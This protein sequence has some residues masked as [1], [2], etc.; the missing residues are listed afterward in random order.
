SGSGG[1]N[2]RRPSPRQAGRASRIGS[3]SKNYRRASPQRFE[4]GSLRS[5]RSSDFR[6]DRRRRRK[7][8]HPS[9][10]FDPGNSR[11]DFGN[12]P[13]RRTDQTLQRYRRN[14]RQRIVRDDDESR[15]TQ[16]AQGGSQ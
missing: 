5:E 2:Q 15:E 14:E 7:G 6:I 12:R 4:S 13:A 10:L 1:E 8:D 16:A 9:A 3:D 11:K